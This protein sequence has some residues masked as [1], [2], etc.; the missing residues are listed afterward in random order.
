MNFFS[1]YKLLIE[2]ILIGALIAGLVYGAHLFLQHEQ[3]IGYDKRVAEDTARDNLA[4]KAAAEKTALLT[5][6]LKDAQDAAQ[7]RETTIKAVAAA[8]TASSNSLRDALDNIKR[9]VPSA[10]LD[11]LRQST[12]TLGA[13]FGECQDR[14]RELAETTERINSEK[15]TLIE[16]WPK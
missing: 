5:K 7:T 9:N 16:A 8:A 1:P 4:L 15:R 3:Q 11:A 13:V 14:R 10:T 6:Q 12:L 2:V